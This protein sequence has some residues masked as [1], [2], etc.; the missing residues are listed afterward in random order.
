[1]ALGSMQFDDLPSTESDATFGLIIRPGGGG[2]GNLGGPQLIG[3]P[4]ANMHRQAQLDSHHQQQLY[5]LA[6]LQ[7]QQQQLKGAFVGGQGQKVILS[8]LSEC[9]LV[10]RQLAANQRHH[11]AAQQQQLICNC[12]ALDRAN[13]MQMQP[14]QAG[15]SRELDDSDEGACT[16][17]TARGRQRGP[18]LFA[19]LDMGPL[20]ADLHHQTL[21]GQ[22]LHSS[23]TPNG[24]LY[25]GRQQQL[26]QQQYAHFRHQSSELTGDDDDD[27]DDDE[28][29]MDGY[30]VDEEVSSETAAP[31]IRLASS[32]ATKITDYR[33][34]ATRS[35][36]R[37]EELRDGPRRH[38]SGSHTSI[39][40]QSCT[41]G[42]QLRLD[43]AGLDDDS[44]E[45]KSQD[46]QQP[47]TA[48]STT[49]EHQIPTR[50]S[51]SNINTSSKDSVEAVS[52]SQ[53]SKA[54]TEVLASTGATL[55]N[56]NCDD[57]Q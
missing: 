28:D 20:S 54:T 37:N 19:S 2:G 43:Q 52:R 38:L 16:M 15:S 57:E 46:N 56:A 11:L 47:M 35:V 39:S 44:T 33:S 5:N 8:H 45:S 1:M 22:Q 9:N 55:D 51:N 18:E 53:P 17:Q 13:S 27:D 25:G 29:I 3:H 21:K 7:Q 14:I 49:G 36:V 32:G 34:A 26:H 23:L 42:S 10:Q 24:P 48:Q 30:H 6:G 40:C 12:G 50:G 4:A 31:P 41:C